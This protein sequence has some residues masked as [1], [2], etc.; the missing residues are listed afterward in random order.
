MKAGN[1]EVAEHTTYAVRDLRPPHNGTELEYLLG[2]W[3]KYQLSVQNLCLD[4]CPVQQQPQAGY[5]KE[6]QHTHTGITWR[7][8]DIIWQNGISNIIWLTHTRMDIWAQTRICAIRKWVVIGSKNIQKGP[9]STHL[10]AKDADQRWPDLAYNTSRVL[11][12]SS[13]CFHFI[14]IWI[15]I[16]SPF[17]QIKIGLIVALIWW[18]P[19]SQFER[20]RLH[21][22]EFKFHVVRRPCI[23]N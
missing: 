13:D 14:I 12:C 22:S 19:K 18:T 7:I 9:K 20:W 21:L 23:K 11:G 1:L 16:S 4:Y 3:N 10:F 8:G 2:L 5:A 15:D 17:V 6:F